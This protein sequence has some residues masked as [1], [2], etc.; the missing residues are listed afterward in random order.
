MA[1]RE[2]TE[3]DLD[4]ISSGG[5]REV[6]EADLDPIEKELQSPLEAGAGG[7]TNILSGMTA[8]FGDEIV[9]GGNAALDAVLGGPGYDVRLTQAR[10]LQDRFREEN[11]GTATVSGIASSLSM[12]LGKFKGLVKNAA[13]GLG[14]GTAFGFGEG[15]GGFEQRAKQGGI[16]GL[17]GALTGGTLGA[18]GNVLEKTGAAT[19]RSSL[20]IKVSDYRRSLNKAKLTNDEVGRLSTKLQN[21]ADDVLKEG[22]PTF[23]DANK[24]AEVILDRMDKTG[25]YIDDILTLADKTKSRSVADVPASKTSNF[26]DPDLEKYAFWG[27]PKAKLDAPEGQWGKISEALTPKSQTVQLPKT[28]AFLNSNKDAFSKGDL[29]ETLSDIETK[30]ADNW[31]GTLKGLWESRKGI[32]AIAFKNKPQG[33]STTA[34]EIRLREKVY[35]DLTNSIKTK[36]SDALGPEAVKTFEKL[37]ADYSKY[38]T[39][40]DPAVQAAIQEGQIPALNYLKQ[41]IRTSGGYGVPLL[42]GSGGLAPFLGALGAETALGTTAGQAI[43]GPVM[44][45]VG[46]VTSGLGNKPQ[47]YLSPLSRLIPGKDSGN[48]SDYQNVGQHF[49]LIPEAYGDEAPPSP[50]TTR[51]SDYLEDESMKPRP[52]IMKALFT[53]ESSNNPKAV[54]PKTKYGTAKGLGQLLDSTGREWAKK[55]GYKSYDPFDKEQNA[56]IS[57]AYFGWLLDEFGGSEEKALAAYNFGIGNV[58]K[59]ISRHGEG[60][61]ENL[62]QETKKYVKNILRLSAVV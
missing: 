14:I 60:W 16:G 22:L 18:A 2:I 54:G 32:G 43:S 51:I 6:T 57:E 46:K 9:A 37:N 49:N 55:L 48:D 58:K 31:D 34:Q 8:G 47:T 25:G 28:K 53:Q 61:K 62:P 12:P 27:I 15:E 10:E 39:I 52:E 23:R 11:P 59:A 44:K 17:V 29:N 35:E 13:Q 30:L 45:A 41:F 33:M 36:L 20:G 7:L 26:I 56:A 5:L 40:M 50:N 3:A 4:P 42:L 24:T 21:A 1:I 19:A 38:S